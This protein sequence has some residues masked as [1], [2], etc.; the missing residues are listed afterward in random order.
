MFETKKFEEINAS[1]LKSLLND[2]IARES[3]TIDY[4]RE[5]N[6]AIS[7]DKKEFLADISSFANTVGG[8][9]FYG[10][11]ESDGIPIAIK[12]IA[13]ENQDSD[14]LRLEQ[15]V[16]AG[17][18]PQIN[19]ANL[20]FVP[21]DNGCVLIVYIP[22]SWSAPH[23]V[24]FDNHN[25]FYGRSSSGKFFLD[26]GELR[27]L[28]N[29]SE[30]SYERIRNFRA[31]RIAKII[32]NMELPVEMGQDLAK[33][34]LHLVPFSMVDPGGMKIDISTLRSDRSFFAPFGRGMTGSHLNFDGLVTFASNTKPGS[35]CSYTQVF[36]NGCI[37][38]VDSDMLNHRDKKVIPGGTFDLEI[39]ES[40]TNYTQ[41]LEKYKVTPPFLLM[42]SL[43]NVK[44]YEMAV[45]PKYSYRNS[46]QLI[47][48]TNLIVPEVILTDFSDNLPDLMKSAFDSVWNACGWSGSKNYDESG[49]W[50][51]R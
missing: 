36:R 1:D 11:D 16:R 50:V 5:L 31:E 37:E 47:D 2:P 42:L 40:I 44:G 38:V 28:F 41:V 3:R 35:G 26:V 20:R 6:V 17:I 23:M 49:N 13:I 12:L 32:G 7:K 14:I 39:L 9:L 51:G 34:L 18:R 48:R 33:I 27:V 29:L 43:L 10:I 25:K 15:I 45:D 22:K 30:T 24:T 21:V 8:Y 19:G 4:K 46:M